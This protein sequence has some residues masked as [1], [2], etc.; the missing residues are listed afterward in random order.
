MRN[1]WIAII[2]LDEQM[3]NKLIASLIWRKL[4]YATVIWSPYKKK[5]MYKEAWEKTKSGYKNY[6]KPERFT[7]LKKTF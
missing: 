3:I 5:D 6:S 2:Y 1:I 4:E 7:E